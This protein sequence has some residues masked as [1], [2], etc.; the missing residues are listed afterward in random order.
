MPEHS[1]AEL[2]D[3]TNRGDRL[4]STHDRHP[5]PPAVAPSYGVDFVSRQSRLI[6]EAS[7]EAAIE[8]FDER[9]RTERLDDVPVGTRR[10]SLI[11]I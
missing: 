5:S 8:L 2:D 11:S 1:A 4:R 9:A 3:R 6:R 10:Q 7:R